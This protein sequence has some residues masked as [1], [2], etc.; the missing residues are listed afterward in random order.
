[1]GEMGKLTPQVMTTVRGQIAEIY[2]VLK[3][4]YL[5][6]AHSR[7]RGQQTNKQKEKTLSPKPRPRSKGENNTFK[8]LTGRRFRLIAAAAVEKK[9]RRGGGAQGEG[10]VGKG[11]RHWLVFP[12]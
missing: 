11:G 12:K 10:G 9:R 1:M 3:L 8:F 6:V 5:L 7:D 4:T 2:Y